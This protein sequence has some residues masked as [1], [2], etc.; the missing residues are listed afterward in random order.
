MSDVSHRVL[1]REEQFQN[2]RREVRAGLDLT[3]SAGDKELWQGIERKVLSDPE[4]DDLT[5]GERHALV[6]RLFDSFRGLDILQP[7]VDHPDITE[8]MIN[9]HREIF[10]EQ[11]GEVSQIQLEFESRERLEDIIQMIVSGVNRIVN[12]SSPIV[13]ARLK[14]GSRVNIVLPPIALKGPTMT[15]RKFPSEPMTMSDL[16]EKGALHEEAAEL[17]QQLVRSKFNIFI[18]GGTGS[19]K[20]TFLNALSQFIP[21]DERIITIEDSAELQ[22]VTVPNLVSLETRNANTEGKGEISIRDLIKSSLRMRPNRIV[23][24]EVRGAEALDML[25]AMNTGHDGSL[26]TGHANNISDMIS[27]L[28]TMVL[29]GAE[30]PISVVRQQISSAV[31]I[32]VH[33]SRLRDRSRRVTE[34]S[35][36]IGMKDG[37]VLLNPLFRFQERD[38]REGRII[39]GLVQ[40]GK[41]KQIEKIQMAGLG[42]WLSE[43]IGRYHKELVDSDN[44]VN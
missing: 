20:T 27:R 22:I 33:L 26:S 35:E 31:D 44:K 21:P 38:E 16:I 2:M 41:L 11:E 12:E 36:V 17:L 39:G 23:I 34:I 5:S 3:S 37:E 4:L 28:E 18:G 30:L 8:I 14:D 15:I 40:V 6:Q 19:G 25:Q 13:D 43:Y 10:V 24:G 29:S 32:F 1:D 42:E 9:S 7:L